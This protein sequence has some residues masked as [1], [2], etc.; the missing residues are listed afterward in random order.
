MG[1]KSLFRV[2]M[3]ALHT[4]ISDKFL[5][6]TCSFFLLTLTFPLIFSPSSSTSS[7]FDTLPSSSISLFADCNRTY[8][9]QPDGDNGQAVQAQ[10]HHRWHQCLCPA[11]WL[12]P[13]QEGAFLFSGALHFSSTCYTVSDKVRS[14]LCYYLKLD[15]FFFF[16]K[17]AVSKTRASDTDDLAML[18]LNHM[19]AH[20]CLTEME[21]CLL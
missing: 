7:F 18:T 3:F 20:F 21:T 9:L 12:C 4:H 15:F 6:F 13:H 19:F 16:V 17:P 10:A 1:K 5:I 11:H 8:R 14:A 2:D